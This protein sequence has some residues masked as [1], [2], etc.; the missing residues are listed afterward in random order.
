MARDSRFATESEP[1]E[2]ELERESIADDDE[3]EDEGGDNDAVIALG[4]KV[5]DATRA[6]LVAVR[7]GDADRVRLLRVAERLSSR[8][9]KLNERFADA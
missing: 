9:R 2:D 4:L 6:A 1:D 5:T 7:D 8:L 3:T